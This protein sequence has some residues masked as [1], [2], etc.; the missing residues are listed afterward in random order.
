MERWCSPPSRSLDPPLTDAITSRGVR[1]TTL[2]EKESSSCF[3]VKAISAH[4]KF[5]V[6][7]RDLV[8]PTS[9]ANPREIRGTGELEGPGRSLDV[10]RDLPGPSDSEAHHEPKQIR[11]LRSYH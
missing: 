8:R 10:E 3:L 4:E 7:H 6:P 1:G 5:E 9:V 2:D 11:E